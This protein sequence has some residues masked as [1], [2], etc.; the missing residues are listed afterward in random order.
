L[1]E[2]RILLKKHEFTVPLSRRIQMCEPL[3]Q[4]DA[5][6]LNVFE[7][8]VSVDDTTDWSFLGSAAVRIVPQCV[9]SVQS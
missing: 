9:T 5:S 2:V 7:L 3:V 4:F 8:S 1:R 6:A